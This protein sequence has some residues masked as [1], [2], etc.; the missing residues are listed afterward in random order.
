MTSSGQE[1][2]AVAEPTG[3]EAAPGGAVPEDE[4]E[5]RREIAQTREQLGETVEQ[6]AA[7]ADV[8]ARAKAKVADLAGRMKV[9][10]AQVRAKAAERGARVRRQGAGKTVM[11]RQKAAAVTGTA[12]TGFQ[13]RAVPVWQKAPE[14]V[15]RTVA[16]GAGAA[17]QRR[18]PLMVAAATLIAV[19]LALRWWRKR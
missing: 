2:K 12:K 15:R 11:A 5:L 8:K 16:Q 19:L 13:A 3:P 14:P 18:V 7:K 4:Q 1:R 9:G 17:K 6:L 10:M